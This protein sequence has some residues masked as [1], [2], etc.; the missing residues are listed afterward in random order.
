MAAIAVDA[1]NVTRDLGQ[2]EAVRQEA[3]RGL[4]VPAGQQK[5]LAPWLFYDAAG[6]RLF[7]QITELPE[8]Y[9]TRAER[10]IFADRADDIVARVGKPFTV[11]ELGSGSAS[12]TGL[13]LAAATRVQPQVLYQPIDVSASALENAA[14]ALTSLV[15]GV[16]VRPQVA[17]YVTNGYAIERP[18]GGCVLA[19]YIGSSIGNFGP[20]EARAILRKLRKQL[21]GVADAILVGVDLAPNCNKTV[22]LLVAA[23]NDS[24]GVTA[25]FNKNI[26]AR[27]NRELGADFNLDDFRHRALWN[28]EDSR[29]EMHLESVMAQTVNIDGREISF[30]LGETI[31]TENSYK[32]TERSFR[33]MLHDSGFSSPQWFEDAQHRFGVALAYPV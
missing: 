4:A 6:S 32:F 33:E 5:A 7:E 8:Y 12:K 13:L 23:Y 22:E 26:L 28:A 15:P 11:A 18:N 20:E 2:V 10:S 21:T 16:T 29:I 14:A 25:A 1:T 17:N 30:A 19:L 9:L 24:A 27:L 31:H 3:L